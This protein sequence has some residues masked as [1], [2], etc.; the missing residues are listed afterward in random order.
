M[1]R[2]SIFSYHFA[3]VATAIIWHINL[4]SVIVNA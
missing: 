3:N 2:V 1:V 4:V